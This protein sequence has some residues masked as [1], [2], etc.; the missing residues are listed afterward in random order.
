M[1]I[2]AGQPYPRKWLREQAR[3]GMCRVLWFFMFWDFSK[4]VR[5]VSRSRDRLK[6]LTD[7]NRML[8]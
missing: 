5:W 1:V 3:K 2:V 8:G 6:K 4:C 7:I